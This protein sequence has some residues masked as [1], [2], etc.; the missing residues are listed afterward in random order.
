MKKETK[1]LVLN[2]LPVGLGIAAAVAG[3]VADG[4]DAKDIIEEHKES[5]KADEAE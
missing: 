4:F 2:L 5:I 3:I 1:R